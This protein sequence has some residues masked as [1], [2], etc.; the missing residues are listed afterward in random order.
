MAD[1]GAP[2]AVSLVSLRRLA[3]R[4]SELQL[5]LQTARDECYA[6]KQAAGS[7]LQQ[8]CARCWHILFHTKHPRQHERTR[9]PR[10]AGSS[11]RPQP[12]RPPSE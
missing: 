5:D 12:Q 7:A 4:V 8:K 11:C 1:A 6:A 9:L 3:C 10:C 2:Q